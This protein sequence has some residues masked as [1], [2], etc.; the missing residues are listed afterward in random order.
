MVVGMVV[1]GAGAA[2]VVA[3]NED[4]RQPCHLKELRIC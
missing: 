3:G 4:T 1:A 2:P